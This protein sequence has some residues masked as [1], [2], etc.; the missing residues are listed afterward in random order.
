[1]LNFEVALNTAGNLNNE[2][3]DLCNEKPID[4]YNYALRGMTSFEALSFFKWYFEFNNR[5][6][7]D[8]FELYNHYEKPEVLIYVD[9]EG[10]M[11]IKYIEVT[12]Y[13]DTMLEL[14]FEGAGTNILIQLL[15]LFQI[16]Q[17]YLESLL[18][19]IYT[20]EYKNG[21]LTIRITK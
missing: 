5:S 2:V 20:S 8:H 7:E 4:S 10:K 21:D 11:Y 13:V 19:D 17:S 16:P 6:L 1:M 18:P 3:M 14:G 9:K 12:F 15:E